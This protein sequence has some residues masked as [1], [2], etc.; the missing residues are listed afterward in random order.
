MENEMF[1]VAKII[2]TT[3]IGDGVQLVQLELEGEMIFKL[4]DQFYNEIDL[5]LKQLE[6]LSSETIQV[7]RRM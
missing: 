1:A 5:D 2:K 3:N 6:K 7:I 4:Q